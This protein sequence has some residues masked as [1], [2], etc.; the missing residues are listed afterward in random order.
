MNVT[1]MRYLVEDYYI[2]LTSLTELQNQQIDYE[3]R[4]IATYGFN[5]G[6]GNGFTNSKTEN[7]AI[8]IRS[9]K[10]KIEEL[11]NKILLVDEGM[12][13]LDKKECE[14]IERVKIHRNKLNRIAKDIHKSSKYVFDTRN[15]ALKK[16]CEYVKEKQCIKN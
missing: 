2:N 3:V 5:T 9:Q 8:K 12:K 16:M 13:I 10:D 7:L 11:E 14:V 6:G 1:K 4:L 15:R